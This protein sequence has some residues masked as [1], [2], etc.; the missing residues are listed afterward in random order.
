MRVVDM[1]VVRINYRLAPSYPTMYMRESRTLS[2][3]MRA[4]ARADLL[5]FEMSV[6]W[7]IVRSRDYKRLLPGVDVADCI[8]VYLDYFMVPGLSYICSI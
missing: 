3:W 4:W 1:L 7:Y 8:H 5:R 2:P 6:D